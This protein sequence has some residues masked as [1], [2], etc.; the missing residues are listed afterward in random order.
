M[1]T[2][3]CACGETRQ[4]PAFSPVD[5]FSPGTAMSAA[6]REAAMLSLGK[7]GSPTEVYS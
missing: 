4:Y 6:K 2:G 5:L 1:V 7:P 3:R